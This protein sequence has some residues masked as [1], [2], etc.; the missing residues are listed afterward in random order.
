MFNTLTL[1]LRAFFSLIFASA[2]FFFGAGSVFAATYEV[3]GWGWSAD[4]NAT[5]GFCPCPNS[6]GLGWISFSNKSDNSAIPYGVLIDSTTGDFSGYAWSPNVGWITFNSFEMQKCSTNAGDTCPSVSPNAHVDITAD[7]LGVIT[8][9]T[10]IVIGWARSCAVFVSG[11]TG[12]IRAGSQTGLWDGW[13]SLSGASYGLKL[14]V[15]AMKFMGPTSIPPCPTCYAWD[16]NNVSKTGFGWG[17]NLANLNVSLAGNSPLLSFW[18]DQTMLASGQ[19]TML[20]W[21]TSSNVTSCTASGSWTGPKLASSVVQSQSTGPLVSS[22]EYNLQCRDAAGNTTPL[23]T[24]SI[25][26]ASASVSVN[27]GCG[28]ANGVSSQLAPSTNLCSSGDA[29]SPV[30]VGD[31]WQ[32]TCAGANGGTVAACF[33]PKRRSFHIIE[34]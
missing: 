33:A 16:G 34:I 30:Q 18:A 25:G 23:Q 4:D 20:H 17:I 1:S 31:L 27:G 24:V 26:I 7:S 5:Q 13:I 28:A 21:V 10:G 9:G 8:G 15:A 32:W 19:S 12:A 6:G 29:T 2:F 3:T 11:C 22:Q 14:D